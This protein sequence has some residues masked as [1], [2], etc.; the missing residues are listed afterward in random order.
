LVAE[1]EQELQILLDFCHQLAG[2]ICQQVRHIFDGSLSDI[3]NS[4]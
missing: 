1:I 2:I 3:I 4:M